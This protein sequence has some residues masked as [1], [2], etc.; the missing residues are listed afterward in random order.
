MEC[1]MNDWNS[2]TLLFLQF[3]Y[4]TEPAIQYSPIF[5]LFDHLRELTKDAVAAHTGNLDI[6]EVDIIRVEVIHLC[7]NGCIEA[8]VVLSIGWSPTVPTESWRSRS[9][10]VGKILEKLTEHAPNLVVICLKGII[11]VP[12]GEVLNEVDVV[13]MEGS[14]L[15]PPIARLRTGIVETVEEDPWVPIS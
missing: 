12:E 3:T 15:P 1:E 5:P 4:N 13:V 10:A 6:P 14:H 9:T 7:I 2:P 11:V 8:E